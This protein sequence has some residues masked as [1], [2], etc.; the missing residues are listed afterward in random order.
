M[1]TLAHTRSRP[2]KGSAEP[3]APSKRRPRALLVTSNFPRWE[4]D[5]TTPF[6]LHLARDLQELDW[7]VDVLAP[8]APGALTRETLSGLKVERFRYLW[9]ESLETV[10]YQGGAL[11]NLRQKRSN[12]LKLPA[13]VLSEWLAVMRR[14]A[15]GRYD[16]LNSHWIL[17]QGFTGTLAAR[18][19][20]IPHVVTVHGGDVFA[21]RGRLLG[22]CKK[23]ALKGADAVTVNSGATWDAVHGILP[24]PKRIECIP[25]GVSRPSRDGPSTAAALRARYRRA[26]GPLL[27]FVG[28][29]VEEKGVAD[30][31]KAVSLLVPRLPDVTALIVGDGQDRGQLERLAGSLDIAGRVSFTGWV[32]AEQV[33]DHLECA[34]IFVGPSRQAPDGWQEAQGLTFLE[35]MMAQ[36]PV[37]A[38]RTGGIGDAV[39]HE[40]T[41]LLVPEAAPQEI[42]AAV[43]RLVGDTAL[44]ER[45]RH[46][47]AELVKGRYSRAASAKAFSDLFQDVISARQA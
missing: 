4:G 10:C 33:A 37:V 45:L 7:E 1:S 6:V 47:G 23:F 17:P 11:V 35:A 13:L 22:C 43:L 15:A 32:A 3:G 21:L 40:E 31:L 9:P 27:V 44:A 46:G 29:L 34:D 38:T 24:G 30:L 16:L 42:A 18:P 8:H 26:K 5:S 28:R 14:L 12:I 41:G 2:A 20:G 25:M 39:R 36:T 19:L